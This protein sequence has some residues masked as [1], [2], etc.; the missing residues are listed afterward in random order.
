MFTKLQ[1]C[2]VPRLEPAEQGGGFGAGPERLAASH[3]LDADFRAHT[4]ERGNASL[5]SRPVAR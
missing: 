3:C 5:A 1:N 2:R 4:R